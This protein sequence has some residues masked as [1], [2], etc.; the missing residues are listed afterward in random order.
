[1][2]NQGL[3]MKNTYHPEDSTLHHLFQAYLAKKFGQK[4]RQLRHLGFAM[5]HASNNP[6]NKFTRND[7]IQI[8]EDGKN[9]FHDIEEDEIKIAPSA[10]LYDEFDS[11]IGQPHSLFKSTHYERI[12]K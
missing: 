2:I 5:D 11:E 12:S 1:M 7:L 4:E 8:I 9:F 6:K 3:T 10:F